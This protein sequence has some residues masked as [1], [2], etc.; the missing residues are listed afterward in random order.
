M[1]LGYHGRGYKSR[2]RAIWGV[3]EGWTWAI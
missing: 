1:A 2:E 3:G